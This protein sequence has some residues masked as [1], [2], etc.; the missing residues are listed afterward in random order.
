MLAR[1][2]AA[3][4]RLSQFA[5]DASHELRTP[6]AIIQTSGELALRRPRTPEQYRESLQQITAET[7]RMTQ[8]VEDLLFL[9]RT[10]ASSAE[11][12][13]EPLDLSLVVQEACSE[14]QGMAELRRV[15]VAR[16]VPNTP[17]FVKGNKPALRRLFLVLLDNAIKYSEPNGEVRVFVSSGPNAPEVVIRDFGVG[18]GPQDLP[19]IFERFYRSDNARS[20]AD[21][22]HGLGLA[23]AE[24]IARRHNAK[25]NVNSSPGKGSEFRVSFAREQS[26]IESPAGFAEHVGVGISRV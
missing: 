5:A 21:G 16:Q 22:G 17:I 25:I 14:R 13:V 26:L 15:K 19:H 10:D 11:M 18:I 3:I 23:L 4:N 9:A 20:H 8:L 6:L 24:S 1:L 2:D 7:E 12:P